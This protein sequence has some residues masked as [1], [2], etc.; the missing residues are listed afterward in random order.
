MQ[1]E[2]S[3]RFGLERVLLGQEWIASF[4]DAV[5]L[6]LRE[7]EVPKRRRRCA[8]RA[9]ADDGI[10][11]W[12]ANGDSAEAAVGRGNEIWTEV[13]CRPFGGNRRCREIEESLG[14]IRFE[15][16]DK[17]VIDQNRETLGAPLV[18]VI[19]T[20][21]AA[22]A[23]GVAIDED[24]LVG[25]SC[26]CQVGEVN[27]H[28]AL[29]TTHRLGWEVFSSGEA[30]GKKVRSS[31][32]RRTNAPN[33]LDINIGFEPCTECS[34]PALGWLLRRIGDVR[35]VGTPEKQE[36]N[37]GTPHEIG[38]GRA[39]RRLS[40]EGQ[41]Q[42]VVPRPNSAPSLALAPTQCRLCACFWACPWVRGWWAHHYSL[43]SNPQ[44]AQRNT[45][46][47]PLTFVMGRPWH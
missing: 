9:E 10:G 36:P 2:T 23:P 31:L 6:S 37:Y 14:G 34:L 13:F 12:R 5:K 7:E 1:S 11:L 15:P 30:M 28:A 41:A 42:A 8:R 20:C 35:R 19:A 18:P 43:L 25:P 27:F 4:S 45:G 38:G 26:V 46:R 21:V 22:G 17:G 33:V 16:R 40:M 29:G 44:A 47:P 3:H 24:C 32:E 39:A